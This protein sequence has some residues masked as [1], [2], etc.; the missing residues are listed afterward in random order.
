MSTWILISGY[1]FVLIFLILKYRNKNIT[2]FLGIAFLLLQIFRELMVAFQADLFHMEFDWAEAVIQ[3]TNLLD[4]I[5]LLLFA[6]IVIILIQKEWKYSMGDSG[7][8]AG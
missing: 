2:F 4:G 6:V 1:F 5:S 7:R 3:L 8:R